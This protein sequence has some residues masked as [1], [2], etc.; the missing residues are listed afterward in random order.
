MTPNGNGG[1]FAADPDGGRRHFDRR[2]RSSTSYTRRTAQTYARSHAG[3][4]KY[5]DSFS[6]MQTREGLACHESPRAA[7]DPRMYLSHGSTEAVEDRPG[8]SL[9]L[10]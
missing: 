5:S 9:L 1:D 4:S 8:V 2:F 6:V 3:P 10:L 7:V